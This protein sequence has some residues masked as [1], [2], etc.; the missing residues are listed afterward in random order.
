ML[1]ITPNCVKGFK[2]FTAALKRAEEIVVDGVNIP[3]MGYDDL[4]QNKIMSRR[5]KDLEDI[6]QLERRRN[7]G[8]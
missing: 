1:D 2:E 5:A 7:L 8:K 6:K 3:L 4:I